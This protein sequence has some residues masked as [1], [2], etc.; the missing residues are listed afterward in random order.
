ME[1]KM[2][3]ELLVDKKLSIEDIRETLAKMSTVPLH[4]IAIV[5]DL[6]EILGVEE[7]KILCLRIELNGDFPLLHFIT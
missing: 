4:L 2:I 5:N 6:E 7:N 3:F 1:V